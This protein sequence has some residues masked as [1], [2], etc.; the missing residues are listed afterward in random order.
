MPV[1]SGITINNGVNYYTD[2]TLEDNEIFE[3][4]LT[5]STRGEYSGTVTYHSG[6]FCLANNILVMR[7][8]D[9]T[10]NQKLFFGTLIQK[11]NYGGYSNYPRKETLA[12]EKIQ[13]PIK[14][15]GEIDFDFMENFVAELEAERVAELKAYLIATDLKDYNLTAVEESVMNRFKNNEI[16]WSEF[17]LGDLFEIKPTKYYRLKNEEIIS[18]CGKNPLISNSSTN[19]GVMGFSNLEPNNKGNTITCSDTTLGADTMFYQKG[20]FIGYS[21]IQNLI[22]KIKF[23]KLIAMFIISV[24]KISTGK[25]YN[26]GNKF[27]RKTIKRTKIQLPTKNNQPDYETMELFVSAV[28]KII[29]KDVV[30][31]T[32]KKINTTKKII[33][34]KTML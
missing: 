10:R 28:Q 24:S 27:N 6:K 25:Q 30:L 7:L 15:N 2:D 18:N 29:I 22:P 33:N 34:H 16:E 17:I 23:N 3:D 20:D 32:D 14:D 1:I 4:C 31:Y 21:H 9:W 8:P 11:L 12:K 5:I 26:Y 19:N 13:L